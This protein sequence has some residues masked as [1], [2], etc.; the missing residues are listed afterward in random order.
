LVSR[1][2]RPYLV[3]VAPMTTLERP[4]PTRVSITFQGKRGQVALDQV[5]TVD[6][7]RLTRRLGT[8]ST[9]TAQAVSSV[10]AE[11]FARE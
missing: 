4:Y 5:R 7:L 11:M 10:L 9:K 3:I 6:R 1:K 8:I 2:S